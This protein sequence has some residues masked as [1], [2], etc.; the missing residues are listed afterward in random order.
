[1][2]STAERAGRGILLTM[3]AKAKII[4]KIVIAW[5]I[6]ATG[7]LPPVL[8][9]VAVLA[10]A[11]VAG[12]PPK[13]IEPIFAIPCPT[14]SQLD[15]WRVPAIP[16]ATTADKSDSIPAKNAMVM[17]SGIRVCHSEMEMLNSGRPGTGS[18]LGIS[19]KRDRM[20]STGI[21][22]PQQIAVDRVIE[23]IPH[24]IIGKKRRITIIKTNV[25]AATP[26]VIGS[27]ED[28]AWSSA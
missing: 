25:P 3:G 6:P 10:I 9:L 12:I 4:Q 13:K 23:A 7:V 20:V 11:P 18:V 26:K 19:P 14:S 16:S 24:G 28:S 5:I 2:T 15:L 27:Q 21:C 17:A 22:H 8:I 1:M